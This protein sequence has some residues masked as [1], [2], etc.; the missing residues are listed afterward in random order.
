MIV[1]SPSMNPPH[2][3]GTIATYICDDGFALVGP[4]EVRTCEDI[5]TGPL[6]EFSDE[7]PICERK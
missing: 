1:Y 4:N 5:G 7:A 2:P 6:G 3:E